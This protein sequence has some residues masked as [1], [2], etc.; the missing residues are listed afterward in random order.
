MRMKSVSF[1]AFLLTASSWGCA[2]NQEPPKETQ[3]QKP[4]II[5]F[6]G[7]GAGLS[8]LSTLWYFGNSSPSYA[9]FSYIGLSKTNSSSHKITDSGAG[10]TAIAI[11]EKS[12]NNSIGVGP[13]SLPRET[14]L[15]RL[16]NLGYHTG[17]VATS[18]ITHATPASFYAH[19][20]HRNMHDDIAQQLVQAPVNFFAG[21]GTK[22]FVRRADGKNQL[23]ALVDAGY[24]MDTTS[25][26]QALS[27]NKIGYLLAH[28]GLPKMSEGR[29]DFLPKATKKAIDHLESLGGPYFLIV[30]GSQIDWGGHANDMP[31][32]I[33]EMA[34][35]DLAVGVALDHAAGKPNT[36]VLAT[37]DHET[38]GFALSPRV[39][40]AFGG[41]TQDDYDHLEPGFTTGGHTAAHVPVFASGFGAQTFAGTYENNLLYHKMVALLGM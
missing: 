3:P 22:F 26:D 4:N 39:V 34:D 19:V 33:D 40:Q 41:T 36:L 38:G 14:I 10:A 30:E 8:Q 29:G 9:R 16:S 15:E 32:I 28:D 35:L 13:D 27:G 6:I 7:D 23:Q 25:I 5:L 2:P 20:K 18:S 31:W 37:A 11:G 24:Q 12:Y 17:V 21:G 1:I